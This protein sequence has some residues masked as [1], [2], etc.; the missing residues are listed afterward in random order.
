MK[1]S[2]KSCSFRNMIRCM[3]T[4]LSPIE[5]SWSWKSDTNEFYLVSSVYLELLVASQD[6][7]NSREGITTFVKVRASWAPFKVI[8][9]FES[10]CILVIAFIILWVSRT[11][12][13]DSKIWNI[14][15]CVL[16]FLWSLYAVRALKSKLHRTRE[17]FIR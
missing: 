3:F 5:D 7:G 13:S 9:P 17:K 6:R 15:M 14:S 1:Q 12:Y 8:V 2:R 16:E 4:I 10:H 11:S